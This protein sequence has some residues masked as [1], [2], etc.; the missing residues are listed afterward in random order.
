MH[1]YISINPSTV[2]SIIHRYII[3]I[4]DRYMVGKLSHSI[5]SIGG[6]QIS[7]DNAYQWPLISKIHSFLEFLHHSKDC[8][9]LILGA[10]NHSSIN[11]RTS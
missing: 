6:R 10:I 9:V 1:V 7:G 5:T 2:V 11:E 4:R 3:G 8:V